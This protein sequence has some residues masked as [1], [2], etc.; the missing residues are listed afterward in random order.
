MQEIL[1]CFLSWTSPKFDP[2]QIRLIVYQDCE[3]RGR[4]VLFDSNA[5]KK[6]TEETP[7]SV[8]S[9]SNRLKENT[10]T[11]IL[12]H[13]C[14]LM[15]SLTLINLSIIQFFF[16]LN[17]LHIFYDEPWCK[18]NTVNCSLKWLLTVRIV[19]NGN[20]G[21]MG[22]YF[23]IKLVFLEMSNENIIL[24]SFPNMTRLDQIGFSFGSEVET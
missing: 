16:F 24:W 12:I 9:N 8:R 13:T 5:K 15:Y 23:C 14:I 2:S 22:R 21:V 11:S 10:W 20:Y 7:V 19:Q 18:C 17:E 1:F 3:R 6:T 4:N